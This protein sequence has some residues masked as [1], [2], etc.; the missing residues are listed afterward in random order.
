MEMK[1]EKMKALIKYKDWLLKERGKIEPKVGDVLVTP[2]V[3]TS[4]IIPADPD[5]QSYIK[6]EG[7]YLSKLIIENEHRLCLINRI[8]KYGIEKKNI[9][10]LDEY[11]IEIELP[12]I[13]WIYDSYMDDWVGK[14]NGYVL[15]KIE[16]R[17]QDNN[18]KHLMNDNCP[19]FKGT[20]EECKLKANKLLWKK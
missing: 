2:Q 7:Q 13:E 18:I 9:D 4:E 11:Y 16:M 17:E 8:R 1:K 14:I 5:K 3:R 10:T 19:I 6:E 20:L 12:K 15:F